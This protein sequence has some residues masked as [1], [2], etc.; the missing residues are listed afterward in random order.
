MSAQLPPMLIGNGTASSNALE[1]RN[2]YDDAYS[3]QIYGP[4]GLDA[5]TF[6]IEVAADP[7]NPVWCRL[8]ELAAA[9]PALT[10]V[11]APIAS[12]SRTYY[13]IPGHGAFRITSLGGNVTADR[14]FLVRKKL[15]EDR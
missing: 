4:V 8:Q 7:T 9:P 2:S 13:D 10:D 11:L 5:F 1:S 12:R 15:R 14:T 6:V 3:I